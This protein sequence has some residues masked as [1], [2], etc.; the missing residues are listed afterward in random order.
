M[1]KEP[2]KADTMRARA[3]ARRASVRRGPGSFIA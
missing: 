1:A 3:Q 2:S